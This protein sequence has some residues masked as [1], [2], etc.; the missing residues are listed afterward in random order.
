MID[1]QQAIGAVDENG[2]YAVSDEDA[3][4]AVENMTKTASAFPLR[5]ALCSRFNATFGLSPEAFAHR[6]G[7]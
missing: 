5:D 1:A 3:A 4:E 7:F 2:E 6:L